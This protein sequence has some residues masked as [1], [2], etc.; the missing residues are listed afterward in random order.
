MDCKFTL[1]L[2]KDSVELIGYYHK[3]SVPSIL[4]IS[5]PVEQELYSIA[6]RIVL[7]HHWEFY[8]SSEDVKPIPR[9]NHLINPADVTGLRVF[10]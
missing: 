5:S 8:L 9:G 10:P 4:M 2:H 7:L 1:L 6:S 3:K